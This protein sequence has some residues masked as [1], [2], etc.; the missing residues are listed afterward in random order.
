MKR[1]G[2]RWLS[3]GFFVGVI[4]FVIIAFSSYAASEK[5]DG[6]TIAFAVLALACFITARILWSKARWHCKCGAKGRVIDSEYLGKDVKWTDSSDGKSSTRRVTKR[7]C[8]TLKCP[9]CGS[10]WCVNTTKAGPTDTIT[11]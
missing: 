7:Y 5:I 8:L 4:V 3:V 2:M 6:G 11:Y 9:K 10:Q 1:A